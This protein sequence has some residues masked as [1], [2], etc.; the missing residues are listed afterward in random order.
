MCCLAHGRIVL[1]NGPPCVGKSTTALELQKLLPGSEIINFDEVQKEAIIELGIKFGLFTAENQQG[2]DKKYG[3]QGLSHFI[4]YVCEHKLCTDQ[5]IQEL[6]NL[7]LRPFE[8]ISTLAQKGTTVL[9][10]G[11]ISQSNSLLAQCIDML[12]GNTITFV[13]LYL[14]FEPTAKRY[15]QSTR[16]SH[17]ILHVFGY[18]FPWFYR[19]AEDEHEPVLE[20]LSYQ[21]IV[22]VIQNLDP[23]IPLLLREQCVKEVIDRFQLQE[24]DQ[25]I[26]TPRMKYDL[27]IDVQELSVADC[28]KKIA[29]HLAKDR[30]Q[31]TV[32]FDNAVLPS[33]SNLNTLQ[34]VPKL[35]P[36]YLEQTINS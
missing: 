7:R 12:R 26:L 5:E 34:I 2:P 17:G 21:K 10:D 22:S 4:Q 15:A 35:S 18:N 19:S 14:P 11:V 36:K 24:K 16:R 23:T 29:E 13:L 28:A 20:Q 32:F 25:V 6:H 9:F 8:K 3:Y 1:L 31:S 27:I 30:D 33:P